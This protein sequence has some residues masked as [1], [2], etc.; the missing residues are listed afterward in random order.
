[1]RDVAKDHGDDFQAAYDLHQRLEGLKPAT[2]D[3]LAEI[4]EAESER[5]RHL[6]KAAAR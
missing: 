6:G 2:Y 3:E 4:L 5:L 1:M